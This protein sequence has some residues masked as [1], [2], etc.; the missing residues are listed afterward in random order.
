MA[1]NPLMKPETRFPSLF[2][3]FFRPWTDLFEGSRLMGRG[4]NMPAVNI[5]ENGNEYK[6]TVAAPGLKSGDIN[7]D[8]ENNVL[9]ISAEKEDKLEEK[10]ERYTRREYNYTSFSRSFTLPNDVKQDSIEAKYE[11]GVLKLA[12]PKKEEARKPKVSKHITVK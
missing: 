11:D 4:A 12:L 9:T 6:V 5:V 3:D 10:D 2:D 1:T 8:V 7:I